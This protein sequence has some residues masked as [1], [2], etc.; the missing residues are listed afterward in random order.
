MKRQKLMITFDIFNI[1]SR[2]STFGS[3]PDLRKI[4]AKF[5]KVFNDVDSSEFMEASL[6]MHGNLHPRYHSTRFL[7]H[8][9]T[10][11][12]DTCF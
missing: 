1:M 11:S 5:I 6:R 7:S 10:G 3:V 4:G 8:L 9:I 12:F 2:V